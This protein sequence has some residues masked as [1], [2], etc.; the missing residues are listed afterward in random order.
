M[1][2]S[3]TARHDDRVHSAGGAQAAHRG[4]RADRA[5]D[6]VLGATTRADAAAVPEAHAQGRG[7]VVHGACGP[8][9]QPSVI[10]KTRLQCL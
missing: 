10:F 8:A 9:D 3:P 6:A 2:D 5:G 7:P 4:R 1:T